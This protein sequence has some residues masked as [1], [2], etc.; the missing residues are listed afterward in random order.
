M[1]IRQV[2]GKSVYI[3]DAGT[4]DSAKTS[5]GTG[6]AQLVSQLRWQIWEASKEAVASQIEFEKMGYQ[7][8]LDVFAKQQAELQ[9]SLSKLRDIK[10]KVASGVLDPKDALR[11]AIA[12]STRVYTAA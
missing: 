6:Y 8:Q 3:I 4:V 11:L 7:A 9:K 5:T 1:P 12:D 2:G 10:S